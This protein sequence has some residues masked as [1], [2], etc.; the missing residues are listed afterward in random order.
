MHVVGETPPPVDL[1]DRDPLAVLRLETGIPVDR[2]LLQLE[3]ELVPCS[4]DDAPGRLAEMAARRGIEDDFG[5][6]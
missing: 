3:A 6:G 5:Y 1:D 2:D 4:G